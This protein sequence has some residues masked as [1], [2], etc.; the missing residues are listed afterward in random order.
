MKK[1]TAF[2]LLLFLITCVCQPVFGQYY[3]VFQDDF[4]TDMGWT[5]TSGG[6]F[7]HFVLGDCAG[8]TFPSAGTKSLQV[9][10]MTGSGTDCSL[11]SQV[12]FNYQDATAGRDTI[13]AIQT[14]KANVCGEDLVVT[15][16]YKLP[17]NDAGDVAGFAYRTSSSAP[18]QMFTPLA[19]TATWQSASYSLP[20]SLNG[21]IFEFG[22][23][24][25][26]DDITVAGLPLAID[27]FVVK[28]LDHINPVASCP[29][30]H[31]VYADS[32]CS[33]LITDFTSLV[34]AT[35]NCTAT[36]NLTLSQSPS[37]GI[38]VTGNTT[39]VFTVK[40]AS[41]NSTT[42]STMLTLIDTIRPVVTCNMTYQITNNGN[43]CLYTMPDVTGN[44]VTIQDNCSTSNFVISQTPAVG[45]SSIGVKTVTVEVK[46]EQGNIG[47]CL[48]KVFPVDTILPTIICPVDKVVNNGTT[49][50]YIL[51][52]YTSEATVAD[53]CILSNTNQYPEPGEIVQPGNNTITLTV[54]DLSGNNA[55][56]SFNVKVIET[57]APTFTNCPSDTTTCT[58][59]VAFNLTANDNCLYA[60][61]KKDNSGFN[62]GDNFPVGTTALQYEARDSSGNF[63]TCSFSV[64][65]L[66]SPSVP[67][68]TQN[69]IELCNTITTTI[70]AVAP[71]S[72]TGKWSVPNNS[73]V[74]I[75]D[76]NS[77]STTA[78]N[79]AT[80][81][82]VI[83]WTV[84]TPSCGDS[85]VFL[86]VKNN[87]LP[88]TSSIAVDTSYK[89]SSSSF[90]LS[91]QGPSIG[92]GLWTSK[93]TTVITNPTNHNAIIQSLTGG[94]HTFYYTVKNGSCPTSIDSI[95]I[96]GMPTPEILNLPKDT[97]ICDYVALTLEGTSAPTGVAALWYFEQ[98]KGNFSNDTAATTQ[99][100]DYQKGTNIIVYSFSNSNCGITNDT[101]SLT[102][103]MCGGEEFVIPTLITPNQDGKNDYFQ[104]DGLNA[105]YPTCKV[106]IINRWGGVVFESEGYLNAWDGT[107][108]GKPLPVGTYY[109]II[110]LN[111]GSKSLLR[112]AISIIR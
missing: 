27:Q 107:H 21:T 92:T 11:G 99:L 83:I 98:G 58:S 52:D 30:N 16:D 36:A 89:C 18:W 6:G 56:C 2:S 84:S 31:S 49:C 60:I 67:T 3:S 22:F 111:D 39:I 33:Y 90:V 82:N 105:K 85:S 102:Y 65:V 63:A 62:S 94:W 32:S 64:T 104:I 72:G 106:S 68:L 14:I 7:N 74:T 28:G 10:P 25:T 103:D 88:S 77:V 110:D 19:A 8:N 57:V 108:K 15:F 24:Y 53:N 26:V 43:N 46:D 20:A 100:T 66:A 48:V 73:T 75:A 29:A 69:P 40:D 101:I 42:C 87:A 38:V 76:V 78:S 5:L 45:T 70:T 109:Y 50:D 37:V 23:F 55:S 47:G 80:G 96:F 54:R 1:T 9:A 51:P 61:I 91:A 79:L 13:W 59:L 34:T 17:L 35:D 41:N 93:D 95:A 112:G 12:S 71:T 86:T 44:I 4:E 97:S 81:D